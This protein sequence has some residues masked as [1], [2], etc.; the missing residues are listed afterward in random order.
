MRY[1]CSIPMPF[2]STGAFLS[3]TV[4]NIVEPVEM[5]IGDGLRKYLP[6]PILPNFVLC[7]R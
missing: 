5:G 1:N 7:Q 6:P 3:N 2:L 4:R